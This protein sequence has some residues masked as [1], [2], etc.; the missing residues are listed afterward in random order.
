VHTVGRVR[1]IGL[2]LGL[3]C[4]LATPAVAD[5]VTFKNGRE[6]HGR[7][8]EETGDDITLQVGSGTFRFPKKDIATFTKDDDFGQRYFTPPHRSDLGELSVEGGANAERSFYRPRDATL[9]ELKNL[10]AIHTRLNEE[11]AKLGP[12]TDARLHKFELAAGDRASLDDAIAN[13]GKSGA[14]GTSPASLS[15]FGLKAIGPLS[16]ALQVG[17]TPAKAA[18]ALALADVITRGDA[19]DARW[20]LGHYKVGSRLTSLLD[21]SGDDNAAA[22]RNAG[23]RALEQ[24]SGTQFGWTESKDPYPS[25][26]QR[27]ASSK[28]KAWSFTDAANFETA[29][30]TRADALAKLD[31]VWK[32]LDDPK[33]WRRALTDA[34]DA[35]GLGTPAPKGGED[36]KEKPAGEGVNNEVARAATP[37]EQKAIQDAKAKI[38]VALEKTVGPSLDDLKTKYALSSEERQDVDVQLHNVGDSKRRGG[39]EYRGNAADALVQYGAKAID[40]LAASLDGDNLRLRWDASKALGRVS[41]GAQREDALRLI[42]SFSAPSRMVPLLDEATDERAPTIRNDVNKALE[43]ISGVGT[44]WIDTDQQQPSEVEITA[45]SKWRSWATAAEAEASKR[46]RLREDHRKKLN[47]ILKDLDKASKWHD[48]LDRATKELDRTERDLRTS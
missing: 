26:S 27:Q 36:A 29:E 38:H 45:T 22:C 20:L 30:K 13:L 11:Y 8:V 47:E 17:E 43:A 10:K 37:E 14:A 40:P 42:Y 18:A 15:G 9:E 48:A 23:D 2:V 41:G 16:D 25:E 7:L 34:I 24:I 3:G 19:E 46:E 4:A 21:S 33:N 12:S 1:T 6:V 35:F 28:W 31:E 5:T 44:G 32:S 39:A